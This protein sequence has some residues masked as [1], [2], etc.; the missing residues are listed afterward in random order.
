MNMCFS[1]SDSVDEKSLP[2]VALSK[3]EKVED[4]ESSG[5][6][7]KK[8]REIWSAL[9]LYIMSVKADEVCPGCSYCQSS[10]GKRTSS[11]EFRTSYKLLCASC[12]YLFFS[13][14]Q[15]WAEFKVRICLK[16]NPFFSV[17]SGSF[18]FNS[19]IKPHQIR[20]SNH[21]LVISSYTLTFLIF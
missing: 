6:I 15:L 12:Y 19:I 21:L 7:K 3:W 8:E 16:F 18:S 20:H 10:N 13:K 11:T 2:S 9:I 5:T 1:V 17:I 4:S 14:E